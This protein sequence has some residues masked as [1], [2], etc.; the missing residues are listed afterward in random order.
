MEL[1]EKKENQIKFKAEISI[2]LANVI[3]RYVNHIPIFAIDEVEISKNDTALYDETV[4]HRIGLIPL[5]INKAKKE[6]IFELNSKKVGFVYSK[7]LINSEDNAEVVYGNMPITILTKDQE[8]KL[9]ATA[10]EGLG[11]EHSKFSPGIIFYREIFD[12]KINEDCPL[13]LIDICPKKVFEEKNGKVIVN[14]NKKCDFCE[15]CLNKF[16]KK[17]NI[18]PTKDLLITIE[19]FGQINA[20]EI[21]KKSIE[22]IKK[23]LNILSEKIK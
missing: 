17:I 7:E 11:I 4:A 21:F 14:D 13:E 1:I 8:V 15:V 10:K 20:R 18:M 12:V 16:G 6:I 22:I 23:D 2:S 9:K 19:S 5:K 3:R